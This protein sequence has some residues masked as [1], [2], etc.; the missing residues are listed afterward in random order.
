MTKLF[1]AYAATALVMILI[2]MAWAV[3]PVALR[4][5]P[6]RGCQRIFLQ[7]KGGGNS[8]MPSLDRWTC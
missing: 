1:S 4:R 6:E 7:D 2:D 3:A 8:G 5:Q